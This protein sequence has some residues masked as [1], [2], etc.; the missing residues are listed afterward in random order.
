MAIFEAILDQDRSGPKRAAK[1]AETLGVGTGA[2]AT[3]PVPVPCGRRR[4]RCRDRPDSV[5][6][7]VTVGHGTGTVTVG[8]GRSRQ[9]PP[10]DKSAGR[11]QRHA[12]G[13]PR[14]SGRM[15]LRVRGSRWGCKC[16]ADAEAWD[17]RAWT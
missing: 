8:H 5:P 4:Y 3:R 7:S 17:V 1:M 2:G 15:I 14:S 10:V 13:A 12:R 6:R 16:P 9:W 11:R